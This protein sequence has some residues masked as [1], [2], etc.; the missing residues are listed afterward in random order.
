MLAGLPKGSEAK[1]NQHT[2]KW[3]IDTNVE[4]PKPKTQ[5]I[6]EL[7]F[8]QKES[9]RMQTMAK[10]TDRTQKLNC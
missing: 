3:I 5:A 8:T 10:N 4:N 2:G 6:K 7:G 1:G 9:E